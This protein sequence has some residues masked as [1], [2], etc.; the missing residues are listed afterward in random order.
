M[1]LMII[2]SRRNELKKYLTQFNIY[3]TCHWID[4]NNKEMAQSC[5]SIY[6]DQRYDRNSLQFVI[7]KI[8]QFYD[9]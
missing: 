5:I 8:I 1:Y 7:D 3:T 9:C 6:I 4:S 2:S